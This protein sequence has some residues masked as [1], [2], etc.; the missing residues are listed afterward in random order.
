MSM[1]EVRFVSQTIDRPSVEV[2]EF[3]RDPANL[4]LWAAGVS[5]FP[6]GLEFVARNDLGVLDHTVTLSSG[7]SV[8]NPLRVIPN[9]D[10]SEVV[11]GVF[12]LPDY[13][14]EQFETDVAAVATD[15]A[16]LARIL[17]AS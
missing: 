1:P 17:E 9:G 15:L 5:G 11:F 10:G 8:Y 14:D 2:Y 13:T 12:R 4:Q 7:D 16:T 6:D 3:V